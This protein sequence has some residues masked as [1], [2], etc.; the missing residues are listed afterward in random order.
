MAK[1][2]FDLILGVNTLRELGIVLDFWTKTITVDEITLP[3]RNINKL[4]T[5]SR[6]ERAWTVNNML[7][8]PES[9]EEATQ[10]ALGILDAIYEKA[11]LQAVVNENCA[12]LNVHDRNKLLEL[13]SEFEELFDGTLGDWNTEPVSF[14]LKEGAKP[15]HGRAFPVP[16]FHK[17]TLI[18]ELN[19]LCDL[20]V[21]EWQ[22]ASEWASPS[23][24][25]PKKDQ[26]VRFLSDFREVNK[27]I[28]RKPYPIP[29]ISTVLQE[30]EGFTF[31]SALD[32]N[33]GYY[34]IRLDPDASKICTIIFPWGK[35]SY[36]R[37]PMGICGSPDIFQSKMM[38][39]MATLGFVRA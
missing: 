11:D 30:M 34:T 13:L 18:K 17:E 6:I 3:M 4:S 1:P 28:I 2:A 10:H 19:R 25:V 27:R 33:M 37:L 35:Y 8:E 9:T 12:H 15:Y 36:L 14:D 23:F 31:A 38:E 29:K 5:K 26:T 22:P 20:G 16:K 39:L 7:H 21:L 32:L 24:I